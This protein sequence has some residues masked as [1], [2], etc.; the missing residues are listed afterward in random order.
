MQAYARVCEENNEELEEKNDA[1]P[2]S[3]VV[4]G[5]S[6]KDYIGRVERN[7]KTISSWMIYHSI[8][9]LVIF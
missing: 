4:K 2:S 5:A 3:F 8:K 9:V 7:I 1:Y 6:L